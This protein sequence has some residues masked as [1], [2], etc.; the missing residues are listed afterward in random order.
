MSTTQ[1]PEILIENF[2]RHVP[3][4][5]AAIKRFFEL[6]QRKQV[7]K[8]RHVIRIGQ[9]P[10]FIVLVESGCLM[11]YVDDKEGNRHVLQFGTQQWWTGDLEAF[12][13][14]KP[15]SHGVI[16]VTDVVVHVLYSSIFETLCS[17]FP[18]FERYFRILF[19]NALI[20]HQKRI[21]RTISNTAVERYLAFTQYYPKIET[22]VP[23]K[24]VA[25]YLGIT[26]EFL[27]KMRKRLLKR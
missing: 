26:P 3:L 5:D 9:D 23:Q 10:S 16:A 15:A 11:T 4:S 2:R 21:I 19:Q 17:E 1:Y 6:T 27:S 20:N 13:Q 12:S 24:Y 22:I 7:E 25:S 18:V 8:N 14:N